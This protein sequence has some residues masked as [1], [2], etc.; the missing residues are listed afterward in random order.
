MP[1][2]TAILRVSRDDSSF[3][4]N[5][6]L[7]KD[8]AVSD[9]QFDFCVGFLKLMAGAK[10]CTSANEMAMRDGLRWFF[11]EYR[12]YLKSRTAPIPPLTKLAE[13]FETELN[14]SEL[15]AAFKLWTVG[16]RGKLFNSGHDTLKNARYC[17]F[18][19]RDLEDKPDLITAIVYTIFSKVYRDIADENTRA[20]QKR[21]VLDE[22]HRYIADPAFAFLI[23][24][25]ARTGR[26]HNIMLDLI[27]QSINDLQSNAILTN[28]KQAFFF[29]GMKNIE[30]SFSTLQLTDYHIDQYKKLNPAKFEVLYWSD[31]GLRRILRPV[32]DPYTYWLATSDAGERVC[33]TRMKKRFDGNVRR[34]IEELV[35]VTSDCRSIRDRI[36]K[37]QTYFGDGQ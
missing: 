17:Y 16:W 8:Q 4:F 21:F 26:H 14:N 15:A 5:P 34:A 24:Q 10:L 11:N 6:F 3:A 20:V 28:L 33:K 36:V 9:D 37:L 30:E 18:D 35:R 2:E 23:E 22:A 1:E 32:T 29:P 25:I 12:I 13:I 19:L 31:G 27:T 7:I